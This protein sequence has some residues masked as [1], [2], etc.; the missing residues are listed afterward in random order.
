MSAKV[1]F[2]TDAAWDNNYTKPQNFI[3]YLKGANAFLDD[4]TAF[5]YNSLYTMVK[6][7]DLDKNP[8][9]YDVDITQTITNTIKNKTDDYLE[10]NP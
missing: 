5:Q 1:R 9:Y 6:G 2:Y 4:V 3:A 10:N 7:V 8:A